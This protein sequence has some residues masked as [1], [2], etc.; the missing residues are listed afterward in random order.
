MKALPL[1]PFFLSLCPTTLSAPNFSAPDFEKRFL[2]LYPTNNTNSIRL[3]GYKKIYVPADEIT[4]FEGHWNSEKEAWSGRY[5]NLT[6]TSHTSSMTHPRRRFACTSLSK[7][8]CSN[9]TVVLSRPTSSG[10]YRRRSTPSRG[11]AKL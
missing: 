1:I 2:S 6:T 9:T 3:I 11:R 4:E 8:H 7:E 5:S 10:N